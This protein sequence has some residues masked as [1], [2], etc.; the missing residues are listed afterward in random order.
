MEQ[1]SRLRV[2][3]YNYS[4]SRAFS[5][6]AIRLAYFQAALKMISPAVPKA[7]PI[8]SMLP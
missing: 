1:T 4:I 3:D 6:I 5:K 7:A 8:Q 2:L